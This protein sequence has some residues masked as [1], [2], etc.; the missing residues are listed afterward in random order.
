MATV[1][2]R[3]FFGALA[4]LL[5]FPKRLF[6]LAR[7][8]ETGMR[9]ASV[10]GSTKITYRTVGDLSHQRKDFIRECSHDR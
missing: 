2:R 6:G 5:A 7:Q 3:F 9:W 1:N 10:W 4:S 8:R